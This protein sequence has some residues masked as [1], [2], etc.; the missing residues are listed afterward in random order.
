MKS[1]NEF[2][3]CSRCRAI[4]PRTE[5]FFYLIIDKKRGEKYFSSMCRPCRS[6]YQ[7][8]RHAANRDHDNDLS[9]QRIKRYYEKNKEKVREST[10]QYRAQ[11]PFEVREW[12]RQRQQ[13]RRARERN[14][15]NTFTFEDWEEAKK[16]FNGVCAYCGRGGKLTQ[17]HFVPVKDGGGYSADNVLP[18]CQWCNKSKNARPFADWY[19]KQPFYS[20]E[21]EQQILEYIQRQKEKVK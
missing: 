17:D 20:K 14:L 13:R 18:V 4:L 1:N 19:K 2:K 11:H 15:R 21:R 16:E 7:K 6:E 8:E 9:R 10:K 5:Q 12:N 3:Q